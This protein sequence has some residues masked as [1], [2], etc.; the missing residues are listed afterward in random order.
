MSTS[1]R[2][3]VIYLRLRRRSSRARRTRGSGGLT[4]PGFVLFLCL[5]ASQAAMLVL[6]P[7]LPE[8]AREFGVSTATAGQLRSISGATGG[9]TA[10]AIAVAR[11][12]PGLRELLTAGAALVA[13]GSTLSAAAP[14]FALLAAAQGLLG[15]GIGLLVA[16]GI[17]AAGVWP[18]RD[19]RAH[20]LACAIAGMPAA[21]II[22]MPV[23]GVVAQLHWRLA[24]I[25]VP[26]VVALAAVVLLRL[27][28]TDAPSR[29]TGDA[30]GTW[31][32]ADVAR[33]TA[34]ELL[35]NAA[36]ASVLTY[37]GALLLE[38]YDLSP[39][40]V[41]LG[42]GATAAAM[43]PGT[44]AARRSAARG[45]PA[46][47]AA[48]TALQGGAVLVLGTVRPSAALTLAVLGVMAY[49]NGWRSMVASTVGMDAAPEDKVA[50][51]AMRAAANQSGYLL[52]A[53]AGGLALA[54]A[55]FAGLGAALS[56]MF[57][58]AVLVQMPALGAVHAG[59]ARRVAARSA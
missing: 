2:R 12:R 37:V 32:R 40:V 52:G 36:W 57:F 7:I 10:I 55:G 24:W 33:F 42:L 35:A 34:G 9:L 4:A 39:A 58:F 38:S 59:I 30:V 29:R 11:R 1:H 46:L 47:L 18:A 8:I 41:A 50:V 54:V 6:S 53:A 16:V 44:F 5:F 45:T 28:P 3:T 20:V 22:G 26:T 51:M 49:T 13:L 56:T 15:I 23:V 19:R 43:L 31:R 27:R 48:L 21:W 25:A 17:A 14:S